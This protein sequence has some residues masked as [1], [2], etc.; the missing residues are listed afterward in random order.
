[1]KVH[2]SYRDDGL[3][4]VLRSILASFLGLLAILCVIMGMMGSEGGDLVFH[5]LFLGALAYGTFIAPHKYSSIILVFLLMTTVVGGFYS[6]LYLT[7]P[8]EGRESFFTSLTQWY[9]TFLITLCVTILSAV[10]YFRTRILF[11]N[12]VRT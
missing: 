4:T 2:E 7:Q 8:V 6:H 10:L 1:M 11:E 5:S 9:I 3:T 12:H